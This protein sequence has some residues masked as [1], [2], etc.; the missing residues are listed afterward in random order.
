[1][2]P[3]EVSQK[4]MLELEDKASQEKTVTELAIQPEIEFCLECGTALTASEG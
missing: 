3:I 4:Y 2:R 1:M